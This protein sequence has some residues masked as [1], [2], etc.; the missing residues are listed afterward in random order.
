MPEVGVLDHQLDPT[1]TQIVE[2]A[3]AAEAA[4]ADWLTLSDLSSWRDVW[5]MTALA[6]QATEQ[7]RLGPGVTNPFLRHPFHTLAALATLHELSGGRAV[8]GIGAG[9]SALSDSGGVD[10]GAAPRAVA[11]LITRLRAVTA[12]EPLDDASGFELGPDLP[13]TPVLVAGR[14]DAML[15]CAGRHA[16]WALVWRIPLSDLERTVGMIRRGAEEAGRDE[17]PAIVW[18]PLVAWDDR[19]EPY[20]RTA[21]VYSALESPPQLFERWGLD[22]GSR[23]QIREVVGRSGI[24]AAARLVPE[25][26]VADLVLADADPAAVAEIGRSIGASS[27]AIRN[28]VIDAVPAGIEWAREVAA[29]L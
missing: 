13:E 8:L 2:L 26:V 22:A 19:I 12:G 20:L 16:D 1:P 23:A 17:P 29:R 7:I 25:P 11:D 9:G 14:K 15:R 5:M 4:G 6:S 10:R 18:C 3:R 24:E 28:F 27:I 21:T